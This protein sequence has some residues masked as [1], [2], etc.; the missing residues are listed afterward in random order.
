MLGDVGEDDSDVLPADDAVTVE[1]VSLG[2]EA[3]AYRS[4]TNLSL[5]SN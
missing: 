5:D 4:N 3:R 2:L 1:V